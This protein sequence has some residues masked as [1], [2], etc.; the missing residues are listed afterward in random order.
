MLK[1]SSLIKWHQENKAND[2][3]MSHPTYSKA[4][5]MVDEIYQSFVMEPRNV[6]LGLSSDDFQA[7][8]CSRTLYSI[9][10]MVLIPSN[11]T[12]WLC[13]KHENFILSMLISSPRS[14][15]DASDV[16]I[17]PFIYELNEL[18]ETGV[19]NFDVSTK[20]NFT[21]H[22]ALLWTSNDF[23]AY[24][25]LSCGVQ[26]DNWLGHIAMNK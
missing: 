24:A 19:V 18:W 22:A 17:H 10:P 4:W 13:M 8:G 20:Q 25:N 14:P 3:M 6:R 2:G 21:L 15:G 12:P 16:Y 23:P 1:T 26:K 5:E 11:V 9:W 7:F